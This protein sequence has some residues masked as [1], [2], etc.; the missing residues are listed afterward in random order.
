MNTYC[1]RQGFQRSLVRFRFD[2]IWLK[3]TDTPQDLE[4]IDEDALEAWIDEKESND[5][6]KKAK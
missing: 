6:S 4:M 1:D 2:G 5:S 3:E